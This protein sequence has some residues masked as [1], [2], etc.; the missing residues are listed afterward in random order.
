MMVVMATVHNLFISHV[1]MVSFA[2]TVDQHPLYLTGHSLGGALATLCSMDLTLNTIP[3][4]E[5]WVNQQAQLYGREELQQ[6]LK[7]SG[8]GGGWVSMVLV[9]IWSVLEGCVGM[10]RKMRLLCR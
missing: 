6:P 7:V 10:R 9:T 5:A 1:F 3:E 8:G 4:V 2:L